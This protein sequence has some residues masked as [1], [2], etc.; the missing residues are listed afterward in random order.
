[1]EH[2]F[3]VTSSPTK[4]AATQGTS[5]RAVA[6]NQTQRAMREQH[7]QQEL[8]SHEAPGV[9]SETGPSK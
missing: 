7:H 8:I 5:P 2:R 4:T 9:A 3:S 1:M 6:S